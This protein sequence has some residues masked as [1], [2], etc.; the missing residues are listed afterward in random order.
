MKEDNLI[1]IIV[2]V[3][4][5]EN[6]IKKCLDSLIKQTYKNIEIIV[7]N[8]GSQDE[9][10]II[11]QKECELDKRVLYFKKK[12]GGL[13]SARNYG[14]ERAKGKYVCFVDSDDW[15]SPDFVEQ[16]IGPLI[17]TNSDISICNMNYIFED[18]SSRNRTPKINQ[19]EILDKNS[20][21]DELLEGKKFRFHA[22]NKMFSM[23][24]FDDVCFKEGKLFED[25]FTTYKL[26]NKCHQVALVPKTLYFYLQSRQGSILTSKFNERKFDI[27]E[28]MD[29]IQNTYDREKHKDSLTCLYISNVIS[30]VNY[31]ATSYRGLDRDRKSRYKETIKSTYQRYELSG[32]LS[33]CKLKAS[34][35]IRYFLI[36]HAYELHM[37]LYRKIKQIK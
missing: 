22:C 1:S 4:N 24:L 14:L 36:I 35:R 19:V 29:E 13:G 8:D 12:N 2:P 9:S 32:Y 26:F 3:Y 20:A 30:L 6:Y 16:L 18:G 11:I 27:L 28:A 23:N 15:V 17:E 25:V 34:S 5:V 21:I 37:L 7:V 10:E 33:N 31:I